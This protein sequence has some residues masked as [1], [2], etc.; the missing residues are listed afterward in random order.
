[1]DWHQIIT[2]ERV[3]I[4]KKLFDYLYKIYKR[5][6][7]KD[8]LRDLINN[9]LLVGKNFHMSDSVLI[10][11]SHCWHITIGDYVTLAP[12]VHILA[13]DASMRRHLNFTKV[14]KVI[15]GNYVF[16]G[17]SS[18]ILP[19]VCIGNNVII[20]AGSVVS[21][22]IP[23]NVVAAGNPAKVLGSIDDFLVRKKEE[24]ERFPRF[25]KE[26]TVTFGITDERK[27]EM[28]EKMDDRY[29]YIV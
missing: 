4:M 11:V 25:G 26:Y 17:A 2:L 3:M 21:R 22:D 28:N 12:R 14:G 10:D 23:D 6:I 5:T 9:G 29:G 19:G 13:H 24:L 27:K 1:M 7:R 18:I 16:I 8:F 20:G 15:I